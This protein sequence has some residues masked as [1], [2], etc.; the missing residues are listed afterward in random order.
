[1]K[2]FKVGSFVTTWV[3]GFSGV[4]VFDGFQACFESVYRCPVL[5]PW[6]PGLCR[7]CL[8]EVC[9][10]REFGWWAHGLESVFEVL[11]VDFGVFQGLPF[12]HWFWPRISVRIV[13]ECL[14]VSLGFTVRTA[15]FGLGL[16]FERCSVR[17]MVRTL[18][19]FREVF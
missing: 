13:R 2:F 15:I 10:V 17:K 16:A 1:M 18:S 3:C 8:G 14:G 7:G 11:V 4:V 12:E 19:I 5:G 9:G 6:L